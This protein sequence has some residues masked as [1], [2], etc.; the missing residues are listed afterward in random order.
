MNNKYQLTGLK[1]EDFGYSA[2]NKGKDLYEEQQKVFRDNLSKFIRDDG[3][4]D[5]TQLQN[6][7][8]P[9]SS[10]YTIFLSHSHKDEEL[11]MSLAG[12]LYNEFEIKTFI[13]SCVWAYANNLLKQ[14]N[15]K[16]SRNGENSFGYSKV[17][18]ASSH[19]HMMLSSALSIMIDK[20]DNFF[21][22][23]TPNSTNFS[24]VRDETY[25]PWL[26]HELLLAEIIG[27]KQ[28]LLYEQKAA[29]ENFSEQLPKISY[30]VSEY[31][32]KLPILTFEDLKNRKF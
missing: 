32:E 6:H 7:C 15:Q 2:N 26:Y 28:E 23:N 19:V 1:L 9:T 22:L 17:I 29:V 8:F 18:F 31:I 11:A 4:I 21:F 3:V 27:K 14:I 10:D 25:S 5:G 16:Y 13:D 12:F 20:C 24:Q 30:N